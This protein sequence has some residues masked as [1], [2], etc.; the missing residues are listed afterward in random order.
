MRLL[1]R[2]G[3]NFMYFNICNYSLNAYRLMRAFEIEFSWVMLGYWVS[4]IEQWPSRMCWLIDRAGD[5]SQE[6]LSLAQ[7]FPSVCFYEAVFRAPP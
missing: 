2:A 7:V 4:L 5:I 3:N 6:H 1:L